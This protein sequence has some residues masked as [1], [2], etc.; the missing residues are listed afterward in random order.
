MCDNITPDTEASGQDDFKP[1]SLIQDA[2]LLP[3]KQCLTDNSSLLPAELKSQIFFEI[4]DLKTLS[5]LSQVSKAFRTVF[6]RREKDYYN[7]TRA[8]EFRSGE[9]PLDTAVDS[10]IRHI[11][12]R[13]PK[14]ALMFFEATW[15]SPGGRSGSARRN[16]DFTDMLSGRLDTEEYD[17][18]LL[19]LHTMYDHVTLETSWTAWANALVALTCITESFGKVA[20]SGVRMEL[21]ILDQFSSRQ[22]E[23]IGQGV[24]EGEKKNARFVLNGLRRH[25]TRRRHREEKRHLEWNHLERKKKHTDNLAEVLQA[26]IH[27]DKSIS[28]VAEFMLLE[29][30]SRPGRHADFHGGVQCICDPSTCRHTADANDVLQA[31]EEICT[32]HILNNIDNSAHEAIRVFMLTPPY[33]THIARERHERVQSMFDDK[34]GRFEPDSE[35]ADL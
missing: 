31:L 19:S 5:N 17:I 8:A 21:W 23:M 9:L 16:C 10:I 11:Q 22:Q 35:D 6:N 20:V 13:D 24:L 1:E 3:K 29:S 4:S 26:I 18:L 27:V 34:Y 32:G 33:Y 2:V 30:Q 12:K 7:S 25:H 14:T 28:A 15:N